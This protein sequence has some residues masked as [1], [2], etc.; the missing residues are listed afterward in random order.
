MS[1]LRTGNHG[2]PEQNHPPAS[3]HDAAVLRMR[4]AARLFVVNPAVSVV[5]GHDGLLL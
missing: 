5:A 3:V 1:H 2:W 4:I